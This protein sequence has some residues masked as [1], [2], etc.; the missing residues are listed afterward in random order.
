M[1]RLVC[2]TTCL[3]PLNVVS[4]LT[5]LCLPC[6][7][8][9]SGAAYNHKGLKAFGITHILSLENAASCKWPTEFECLHITGLWDD[10]KPENRISQYFDK[11]LPF[12]K[13]ALSG[14]GRVLVHCWAGKSRSVSTIA[15]YMIQEYKMSPD[16]A[17]AQIR[18]TRPRAGPNDGYLEELEDFYQDH[19]MEQGG[20]S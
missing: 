10:A 9:C 13:D 20:S 7:H 6:I 11:T 1:D 14:G 18:I 5:M 4:S 16:E 15:A 3:L 17:L 12:I 8:L 19:V 2:G